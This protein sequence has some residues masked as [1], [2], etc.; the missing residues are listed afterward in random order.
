L[1]PNP[2]ALAMPKMKDFARQIRPAK[3]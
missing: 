1:C 3:A 2:P